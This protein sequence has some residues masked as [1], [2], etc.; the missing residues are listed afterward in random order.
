MCD[1]T[2]TK[3]KVEWKSA[4][5]RDAVSCVANYLHKSYS[6]IYKR[7]TQIGYCISLHGWCFKSPRCIVSSLY[8]SIFQILI[9]NFRKCWTVS[10][11]NR[12]TKPCLFLYQIPTVVYLSI[13]RWKTDD[14]FTNITSSMIAK[15]VRNQGTHQSWIFELNL[16]LSSAKSLVYDLSWNCWE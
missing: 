8:K 7:M 1:K 9:V 6:S 4:A 2:T 14:I 13:C 5:T 15:A 16:L 12:I 3:K 10:F 11:K